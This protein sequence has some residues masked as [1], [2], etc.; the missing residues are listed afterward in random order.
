MGRLARPGRA[1]HLPGRRQSRPSRRAPS[2]EFGL[3]RRRSSASEPPPKGELRTWPCPSTRHPR[4]LAVPSSGPGPGCAAQASARVSDRGGGWGYEAPSAAPRPPPRC[5][6]LSLQTA[7]PRRVPE[8]AERGPAVQSA[9]TWKCSAIFPGG[10]AGRPPR[11]PEGR[12]Q[13]R[14]PRKPQP[15][16]GSLRRWFA[17][18][19]VASASRPLRLKRWTGRGLAGRGG[20]T[21]TAR[22]AVRRGQGL[23]GEAGNLNCPPH[24]S[25]NRCCHLRWVTTSDIFP[26]TQPWQPNCQPGP[27]ALLHLPQTLW[28]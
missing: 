16:A 5:S 28:E 23:P 13:R 22:G 3:P 12:E 20:A 8:A 14:A 18:T 4:A 7:A 24:G 15:P 26:L 21:E 19:F 9:L 25:F 6:A 10:G 11:A 27:L 17:R 2:N 1:P